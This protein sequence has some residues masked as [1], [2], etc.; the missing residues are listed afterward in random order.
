MD[1]PLTEIHRE[2]LQGRGKSLEGNRI[3]RSRSQENSHEATWLQKSR[4]GEDFKVNVG[5]TVKCIKIQQVKGSHTDVTREVNNGHKD[6]H[7]TELKKTKAR[8]SL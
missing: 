1:L 2:G 6:S 8:F 7:V 3:R 4:G 5:N